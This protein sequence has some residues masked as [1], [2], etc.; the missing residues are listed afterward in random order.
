MDSAKQERRTRDIA[1]SFSLSCWKTFALFP[2]LLPE[3]IKGRKGEREGGINA[4][5]GKGI[6]EERTMLRLSDA[7]S[8]IGFQFHPHGCI[9]VGSVGRPRRNFS[10]SQF[11]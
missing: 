3:W 6:P 5:T 1:F 9:D 7:A 8:I 4:Q 2:L 10:R 11:K